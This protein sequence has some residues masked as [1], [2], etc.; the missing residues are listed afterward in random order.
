MSGLKYE[1]TQLNTINLKMNFLTRLSKC[2][3]QV[4]YKKC[5]RDAKS[6]DIRQL[7]KF[8]T[9]LL[10]KK[11]SLKPAQVKNVIENRKFYRHLIHSSYSLASKKK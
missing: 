10:R 3:K 8:T 1:L 5:I 2:K 6:Q 4:D 9:A 7:V 11:I